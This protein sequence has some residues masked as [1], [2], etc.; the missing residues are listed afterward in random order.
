MRN[1]TVEGK[2]IVFKTLSLSKM[3]HLC[4][5]SV[6]PK[7]FTEE[8]ENIQKSFLWNRSTPKIKHSPLRNSFAAGGLR[9]VDVNTKIASLQCSSIKWFLDDSFHE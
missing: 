2:I 1:L 3:V 8:I 6:V 9:N 7:Q 5:T 4:L